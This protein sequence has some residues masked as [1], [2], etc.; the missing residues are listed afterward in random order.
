MNFRK[1]KYIFYGKIILEVDKIKCKHFILRSDIACIECGTRITRNFLRDNFTEAAYVDSMYLI[2][3][4]CNQCPSY[5]TFK[6][7][8]KTYDEFIKIRELERKPA[9]GGGVFQKL[10]EFFN[11]RF[12]DA[13]D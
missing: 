11:R 9:T 12:Y 7:N 5:L 8:K 13:T 2:Y 4:F 10:K 3:I 6:A 1:L